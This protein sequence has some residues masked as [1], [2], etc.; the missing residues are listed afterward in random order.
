MNIDDLFIISLHLFEHRIQSSRKV[1]QR[2]RSKHWR[3]SR[4]RRSERSENQLIV[5]FFRFVIEHSICWLHHRITS[6]NVVNNENQNIDED[7]DRDRDEANEMKINSSLRSSD[8]WAFNML[9]TSWNY[10]DKCNKQRRS[11]R[12]ERNE[13]QLN[14]MFFKLVIEHSI[15]W[16]HH[17][18]IL[19]NVVVSLITQ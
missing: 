11:K 14:V 10:I 9:T 5:T 19:I 8:F 17:K 1:I 16:L 12:N 6:I 7:R 4:S 15:R 3:K 18:A 13:D 2:R